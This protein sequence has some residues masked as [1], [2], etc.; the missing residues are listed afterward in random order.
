MRANLFWIL[1]MRGKL[2]KLLYRHLD[3]G[4]R[5]LFPDARMR[6]GDPP[7]P[8]EQTRGLSKE[9]YWRLVADKELLPPECRFWR[10]N[11]E[12]PI[13]FFL[14]LIVSP[15]EDCFTL[16]ICGSRHGK[17]PHSSRHDEPEEG[18]AKD[19]FGFRLG[20]L[21]ERPAEGNPIAQRYDD[22][23]GHLPPI[24]QVEGHVTWMF[25]DPWW[26]FGRRREL[27]DLLAGIPEDPL[28]VKLADVEPKVKDALEKLERYA[29]PYI[30]RVA[31]R[32]GVPVA[33][34]AL[35][36]RT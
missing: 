33:I 5:L 18:P 9:E 36:P 11:H 32:Y 8:L 26:Y 23:P 28:E 35:P 14:V 29:V 27:E 19:E 34:R 22:L 1:T 2:A 25:N 10:L 12:G 21:M 17:L 3:E 13:W 31:E 20:R 30:R 7:P 24:G 6:A 16:E 4:I 15:K